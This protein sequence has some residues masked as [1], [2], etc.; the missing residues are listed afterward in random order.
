MQ[1]D[2]RRR[3][4]ESRTGVTALDAQTEDAA[5]TLHVWFAAV[6]IALQPLSTATGNIGLGVAALGLGL[7]M[8]GISLHAVQAPQGRV[9]RALRYLPQLRR[10]AARLH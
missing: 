10:S 5:E 3:S 2:D 1:A 4:E 7:R 9:M 8:A 6:G